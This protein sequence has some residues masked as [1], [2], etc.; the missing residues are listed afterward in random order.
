MKSLVLFGDSLLG[1]FGKDLINQLESK[2][3]DTVVYN[4]A[5]GGQT[6]N[7]GVKRAPFIAKL[8]PDYVFISFGANDAAPW[9]A[10]T[11]INKFRDNFN[12]ILD[13]FSKPQIIVL[14]CPEADE[15]LDSQNKDFN[16]SLKE[17][18]QV[19]NEIC[20]RRAIATVSSDIY[21]KTLKNGNDYHFGDG[22]H[23]NQHGYEAVI[24]E[25]IHII[26]GK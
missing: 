17:Y 13:A 21:G 22:L 3:N 2:L 25:L 11:D 5:A 26:T 23:L 9:K 7:D 12:E 14:V 15:A 19:I 16:I 8:E 24:D 4:C 18:N 6:T 1:R 10:Q 20:E